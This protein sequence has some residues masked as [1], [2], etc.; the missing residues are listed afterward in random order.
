[1]EHAHPLKSN[2]SRP[3]EDVLIENLSVREDVKGTK[4]LVRS[5][6]FDLIHDKITIKC[7]N[8]DKAPNQRLNILKSGFCTDPK[9]TFSLLTDSSERESGFTL[10]VS[11]QIDG[12]KLTGTKDVPTYCRAGGLGP[13]D[14]ICGQREAEPVVQFTLSNPLPPTSP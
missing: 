8:D 13:E 3:H 14:R 12:Y 6:N 5:V 4:S 7:K 2:S 9:Y 1:M 10:Q 11:H